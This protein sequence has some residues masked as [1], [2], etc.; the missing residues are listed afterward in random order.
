[1]LSV[2]WTCTFPLDVLK[3]RIQT[4]PESTPR[5]LTTVAYHARQVHQE[6]GLRGFYRGWLPTIV[7]SFPVNAA[8]FYVY[9]LTL[10]ALGGAFGPSKS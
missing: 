6:S 9:E 8:T 10:Q 2:Q 1:M 7:R 5:E 3:S 4:L